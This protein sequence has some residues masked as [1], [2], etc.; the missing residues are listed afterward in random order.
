LQVDNATANNY[1]L[2]GDVKIAA[3][4][5]N[6]VIADSLLASNP[7]LRRQLGS[8]VA[9]GKLTVDTPPSGYVLRDGEYVRSSRAPGI[10]GGGKASLAAAGTAQRLAS[11]AGASVGDAI[12]INAAPGNTGPIVV[13]G[14]DVDATAGSENGVV[15]DDGRV[16][17]IPASDPYDVWFDGTTTGDDVG[18]L[19]VSKP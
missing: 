19:V 13:G 17:E 18:W 6:V 1:S 15:L 8:L 10:V 12:L 9:G 16:V 14:S 3:S 11:T 2:Q 5:T 4:A 7:T